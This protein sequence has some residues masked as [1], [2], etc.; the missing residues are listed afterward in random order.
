MA[1]LASWHIRVDLYIYFFDFLVPYVHYRVITP[2]D[3][4]SGVSFRPSRHH[5]ISVSTYTFGILKRLAPYVHYRVIGPPDFHD[6]PI[7]NDHG[8]SVSTY[9]SIFMESGPSEHHFGGFQVN[10]T[11]KSPN[12]KTK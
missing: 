1:F 10:K 7:F 5:D 2:A 3:H 12:F 4:H 9:T 8:I 6:S 11:T